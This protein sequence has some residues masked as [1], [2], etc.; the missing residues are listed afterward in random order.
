VKITTIVQKVEVFAP[1]GWIGDEYLQVSCADHISF[2]V[3][4]T[5]TNRQA[6]A[7][8]RAIDITTA[9]RRPRG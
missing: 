4:N 8:G 6:Y 5:A 1:I 2:R 7:I 9:P 3:K